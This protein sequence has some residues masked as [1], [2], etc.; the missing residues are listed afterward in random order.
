MSSCGASIGPLFFS[1]LSRRPYGCAFCSCCCSFV[2][3]SVSLS[4]SPIILPI[5]LRSS[6]N[7]NSPCQA[8]ARLRVCR[9]ACWTEFFNA[10]NCPEN[11][12]DAHS[13]KR[14]W[15][16]VWRGKD[17]F[18]DLNSSVICIRV[19]ISDPSIRAVPCK[20]NHEHSL[21]RRGCDMAM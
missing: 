18:L 13:G 3:P 1:V 16:E 6:H 15:K 17:C 11:V 14:P 2:G 12:G 5:K 20:E 19:S 4:F 9:V 7:K 10:I 8:L 21:V